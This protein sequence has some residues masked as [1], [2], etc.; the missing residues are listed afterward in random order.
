MTAGLSFVR[1][2]L[3]G[4]SNIVRYFFDESMDRADVLDVTSVC[5]RSNINNETTNDD[6]ENENSI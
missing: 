5:I 1:P 4:F 3:C 2:E 6:Y